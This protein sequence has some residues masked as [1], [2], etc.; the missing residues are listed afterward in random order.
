MS[1]DL[2]P[3]RRDAE[4]LANDDLRF[5]PLH[6][7]LA[8]LAYT[9]EVV[10]AFVGAFA[11]QYLTPQAERLDT[12][13]CVHVVTDHGVF[14]VN[15]RAQPARHDQ[16]GVD[17]D[18]HEEVRQA[19]SQVVLVQLYHRDLHVDRADHRTLRVVPL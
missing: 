4:H 5:L 6:E 19:E 9:H 18:A 14:G 16:A 15:L 7:D 2:L 3:E 8:R 1:R 10:A 11:N 12:R 13:G 17:A